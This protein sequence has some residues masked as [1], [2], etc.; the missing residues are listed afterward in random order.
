GPSRFPSAKRST[1]QTPVY[2]CAGTGVQQAHHPLGS[3]KITSFVVFDEICD[4]HHH[5]ASPLPP[6]PPQRNGATGARIVSRGTARLFWRSSS[7]SSVIQSQNSEPA[8]NKPAGVLRRSPA[9]LHPRIRAKQPAAAAAATACRPCSRAW[10]R[11][12]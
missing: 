7:S 8:H 12:I 9:V 1:Q 5:P 10:R 6:L 11:G 3:L 2:S 4:L